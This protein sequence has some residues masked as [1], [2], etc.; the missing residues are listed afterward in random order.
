MG[1]I[2]D[3]Y[4]IM[5]KNGGEEKFKDPATEKL[6]A[7]EN[8]SRLYFFKKNDETPKWSCL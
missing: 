6:A 5:V 7:D 8:G 2:L 1:V 3:C 4:C